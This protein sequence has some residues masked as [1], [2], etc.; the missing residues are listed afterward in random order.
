[1]DGVKSYCGPAVNV[2][3]AQMGDA[4]NPF[5]CPK[6]LAGTGVERTL[7]SQLL[8]GLGASYALIKERFDLLAGLYGAV[9]GEANSYPVE[10]IVGVKIYLAKNS[11]MSL[12]GGAS[13]IPAQTQ[14]AVW[15]AFLGFV[16]EPQIGDRDGDGLKDD[17]DRCPDDP[18]DH[19]D[20][21]DGDGC[22]DPDNDHDGILDKDDKCPNEPETN[23]GFQDEDR[24]QERRE[25]KEGS[26]EMPDR[27][28]KC[29]EDPKDR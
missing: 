4:Q 11:F 14:G 1:S 26:D 29:P 17:V 21:E 9:G 24:S 23:N 2:Q 15:R 3:P 22:P 8:Y 27:Q 10:G 6:G 13:L 5:L 20:F 7:G 19:D 12:G 28:D 16:F 18:E 25:G